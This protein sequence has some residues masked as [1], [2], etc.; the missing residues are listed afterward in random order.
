VFCVRRWRPRIPSTCRLHAPSGTDASRLW[1]PAI[2]GPKH[3]PG[4]AVV[5]GRLRCAPGSAGNC[6]FATCLRSRTVTTSGTLIA[7]TEEAEAGNEHRQ[8][9]DAAEAL[10]PELIRRATGS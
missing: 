9:G 2:K 10:W 5:V 8:R 6:R 1:S 7:P 4:L 3:N